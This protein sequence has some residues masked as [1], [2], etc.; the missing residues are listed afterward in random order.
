[1]TL[2]ELW[3]EAKRIMVE[4]EVNGKTLYF[5]CNDIDHAAMKRK[6]PE[7][8][9]VHILQLYR[10]WTGVLDGNYVMNVLPK[11]LMAITVFDGAK[12]VDVKRSI[13]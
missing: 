3:Q 11:V 12:V 8:C 7:A 5:V 1:M 6:Y 9:V 2:G 13:V 10:L 4:C